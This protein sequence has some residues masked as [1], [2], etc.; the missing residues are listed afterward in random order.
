MLGS[1]AAPRATGTKRHSAPRSPGNSRR[2]GNLPLTAFSYLSPP[3]A[4]RERPRIQKRSQRWPRAVRSRSWAFRSRRR[5]PVTA[6]LHRSL[7][8]FGSAAPRL[9]RRSP[10]TGSLPRGAGRVES[11]TR[12]PSDNEGRPP[13]AVARR[14]KCGSST[15]EPPAVPRPLRSA[16]GSAAVLKVGSAAARP[17]CIRRRAGILDAAGSVAMRA[18]LRFAVRRAAITA[19]ERNEVLASRASTSPRGAEA[20]KFIKW[21][22]VGSVSIVM[23]PKLVSV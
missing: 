3:M 7:R 22:D 12:F 21:S 23:F 20:R 16:T 9:R 2:R 6:S 15:A 14:P 5:R 19:A 4:R 11:P 13:Y 1:S 10:A 8:S 18:Q 17:P